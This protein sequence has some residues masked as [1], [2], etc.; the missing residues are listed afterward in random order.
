MG[1]DGDLLDTRITDAERDHW[2]RVFATLFHRSAFERATADAPSF[3][4][5]ARKEAAF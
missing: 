3:L 5:R 2:L 1:L 4:E